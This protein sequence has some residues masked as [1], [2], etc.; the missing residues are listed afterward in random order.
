[1]LKYLLKGKFLSALAQQ[2]KNTC[3][4]ICSRHDLYSGERIF[5]QAPMTWLFRRA[6]V[7]QD[8]LQY[9][10]LE[11]CAFEYFTYFKMSK[12]FLPLQCLVSNKGHRYLNKT[13]SFSCRF[14]WVCVI[15]Q[16]AQDTKGLLRFSKLHDNKA[17]K[18]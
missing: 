10:A 2:C 3:Q 7:L 5:T 9:A 14:L 4:N 11:Y 16:Q 1:M 15:L 13:T 8:E 12:N 18:I 6:A 17:L